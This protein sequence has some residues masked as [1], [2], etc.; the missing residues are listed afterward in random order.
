VAR[1]EL[2]LK[3]LR[4]ANAI[5]GTADEAA[6]GQLEELRVH[7]EELM[8]VRNRRIELESR[9]ATG[10]A[11]VDADDP[12]RRSLREELLRAE[13]ELARAKV[14]LTSEHPAVVA[15]ERNVRVLRA[16][17][18]SSIYASTDALQ[19]QIDQAARLEAELAAVEA[20]SRERLEVI[21]LHRRDE[22]KLLSDLERMRSQADDWRRELSGER[23]V[24]QLAQTGDVG[25]SARMIAEPIVPDEPVWPKSMILL[26]AG[27]SLGLIVG[28][29]YALI[30]LQRR[31]GFGM[32][33]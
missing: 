3:E 20:K 19:Q 16:Q 7:A 6:A 29:L 27:A 10:G 23:M 5:L 33:L 4:R 11:R 24:A 32:A 2:Q 22:N 30:S 26:P 9:L 25:V 13:S 31:R 18:A 8:T 14:S 12:V 17:L 15:A 28:F 21:E 1:Q